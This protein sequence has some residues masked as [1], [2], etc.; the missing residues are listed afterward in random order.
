M[1]GELS[2]ADPHASA[3]LAPRRQLEVEEPERQRQDQARFQVGHGFP[4]A[5][6]GPDRE[7][8]EGIVGGPLGA[9][10]PSLRLETERIWEVLFVVVQAINIDAYLCARGDDMSVHHEGLRS[11]GRGF[12]PQRTG[13]WR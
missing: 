9:L 8:H 2:L 10:Q 1:N 3:I 13:D 7:R 11:L 12:A 4:R 6:A 5:A